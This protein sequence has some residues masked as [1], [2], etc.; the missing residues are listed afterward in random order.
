MGYGY[1]LAA[2]VME[3]IAT[4]GLKAAQGFT[5]LLPSLIVVVGYAAAFYFLSLSLKTIPI[6]A[7][8]AIWSGAGV[9]LIS[10]IGWLLYHQKLDLPT[11]I[12]MA[13]II[14]GVA[15]IRIFSTVA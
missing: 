3:V 10:I 9:V 7:A 1:L 12:G 13:M 11:I 2:I 5:V 15:V 8:Y 4:S 6:G 14:G